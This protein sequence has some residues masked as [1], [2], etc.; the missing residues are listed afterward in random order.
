MEEIEFCKSDFL[1]MLNELNKYA[2]KND[3]EDV[4]IQNCTN[5]QA[6]HFTHFDERYESKSGIGNDHLDIYLNRDTHESAYKKYER[7]MAVMKEC[8]LL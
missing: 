5:I 2:I 3:V 8:T 7:M 4:W 6:I 1:Y